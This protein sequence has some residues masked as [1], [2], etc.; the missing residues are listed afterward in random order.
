MTTYFMPRRQKQLADAGT[1]GVVRSKS[2]RTPRVAFTLIELLVV[3]AIIAILA[4]MLLPALSKAKSRAQATYC[5]SNS[6]Q[7]MLAWIQYY[8]DNNDALVNNFG[9]VFAAAEEQNKTYRS[10][11]NN[12]MTW[13][14]A[15]RLGNPI[16]NLDGET[17]A[18]FFKYTANPAVYRCPADHYVSASQLAAGLAARPRSY[19]MNMFFGLNAPDTP[20]STVNATFPDYIQFLKAGS[21]LTPSGLFVT[22]DEHPDSIN[23]G[24]LQTDPHT[25]AVAWN[26]L[27]ASYHNGAGGF[28]FADGHSE[29]HKFK[30]Y[31]CTILPVQFN[32]FQGA[33]AVPFSQDTSGAATQDASWVEGRASVPVQ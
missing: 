4:A 23:D 26:D 14:T 9:G 3:I 33:R 19:S 6:R 20:P 28:A 2:R 7:L 27:P 22:L 31:L 18:P 12:F 30:S 29:I 32:V 17:Q 21:I 16:G 8:T 24:F 11:V 1:S 15:D 25:N 13:N 10:W 5:M